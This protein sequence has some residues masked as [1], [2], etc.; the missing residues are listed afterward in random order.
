MAEPESNEGE[1]SRLRVV[2]IDVFPEYQ[3]GIYQTPKRHK[4]SRVPRGR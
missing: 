3:A 4:L 1:M 2:D